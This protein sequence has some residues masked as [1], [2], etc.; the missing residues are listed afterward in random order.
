MNKSLLL[1]LFSIAPDYILCSKQMERRLVPE[2]AKAWRSF[3]T[4]NPLQSDSFCHIVNQRHFQR[5]ERLI[6]PSKVVVGGETD[7]SQNYIAP[8]IM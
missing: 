8:T 5:V 6:D 4:E 2:I 3:F 1:P 7:A